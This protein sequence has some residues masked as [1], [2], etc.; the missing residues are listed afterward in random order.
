MPDTVVLEHT[1]ADGTSHFDWLIERAP[2][3]A[4][5]LTFRLPVDPSA[6][7]LGL[8]IEADLLPD[9]RRLYLS[10]EGPISGDRGVVRRVAQGEVHVRHVSTTM[11]EVLVRFGQSL[12]LW[13]GE[14]RGTRWRLVCSPAESR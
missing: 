9:H 6:A 7:P 2:G 1:L 5:L 14:A 13:T 12:C 4:R 3:E 11:V 8:S 10:Y